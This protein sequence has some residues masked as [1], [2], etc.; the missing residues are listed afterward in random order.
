MG[1]TGVDAISEI[2]PASWHLLRPLLSRRDCRSERRDADSSDKNDWNAMRVGAWTRV[3][4][5][6]ND[7]QLVGQR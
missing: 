7:S 2:V 6:C 1:V 3:N 5:P 4:K